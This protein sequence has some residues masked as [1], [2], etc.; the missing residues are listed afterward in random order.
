MRN[1]YFRSHYPAESQAI[2]QGYSDL[3]YVLS[4]LVV[5]TLKR[6]NPFRIP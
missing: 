4:T 3:A 5:N 1:P 6:F 2:D